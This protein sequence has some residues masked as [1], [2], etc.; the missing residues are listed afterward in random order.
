MQKMYK[1]VRKTRWLVPLI[2]A[3]GLL[4]GCSDD[5]G[6]TDATTTPE[7]TPTAGVGLLVTS[8]ASLDSYRYTVSVVALLGALSTDTPEALAGETAMVTLQGSRVNPDR[9]HSDSLVEI[10]PLAVRVETIQIGERQW[11]REGT[12][13]WDESGGGAMEVL[14]GIDFRPATLFA[15]DASEYATLG[16]RLATFPSSS[17]MLDDQATRY[18][19]FTQQEFLDIF[20]GEGDIVPPDVDAILA[21]EVWLSEAIGVPVRLLVIGESTDGVEVIRVELDITDLNDPTIKIEPPI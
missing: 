16:E 12:R 14:G 15:E 20:Q 8:P 11:V 6:S 4:I 19:K 1:D 17:V 10:G 21:A 7:P 13:P 2:L 5:D 18:F 3:A 9:E